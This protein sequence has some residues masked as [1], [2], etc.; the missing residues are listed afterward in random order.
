MH[1]SVQTPGVMPL[2][3]NGR[4]PIVKVIGGDSWTV[5]VNLYNPKDPT[6]PATPDNTIVDIVLS[7]T[8]FDDPIWEG[9][10]FNGVTPDRNHK[11]LCH[12]LVPKTVTK[13]LRRGSYM[14]SVRVS[15]LLKTCYVTECHGTFLVEYMP[16]SEQHSIPYK[17]GTSEHG[18][19]GVTGVLEFLKRADF[20]KKGEFGKIYIADDTNKLYRWDG[21]RYVVLN[22]S[23]N[24]FIKAETAERKA[25]TAER[26]A[27]DALAGL[28]GKADLGADGKILPSQLPEV[29]VEEISWGSIKGNLE[30]QEDLKGMLDGKADSNDLSDLSDTVAWLKNNKANKASNPIAGHIAA[31]DADGNLTD[32]GKTPDDF[33]FDE[34]DV[35]RVYNSNN[36]QYIDGDG[37]VYTAQFEKGGHWIMERGSQNARYEYTG[38]DISF[39]CYRWQDTGNVNHTCLYSPSTGKFSAFGASIETGKKGLNPENGDDIGGPYTVVGATFTFFNQDSVFPSEPQDKIAKKSDFSATDPAEYVKGVIQI[40]V[41]D[42]FDNGETEEF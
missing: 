37:G 19:S 14:F 28:E 26:K 39:D 38:F 13:L 36:T 16:T 40:V 5:D 22:D 27:D 30:D 41:N 1:I 23:S 20:P 31:L 34:K 18:Y 42:M 15:D 2:N 35:K 21:E 12:I 10:W 24:A 6:S 11:G 4:K 8:Q 33:V 3:N 9:E 7:E 25:E 32:S 29:T 17:D